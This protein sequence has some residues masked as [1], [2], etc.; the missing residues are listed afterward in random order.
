[1]PQR[2][3]VRDVEEVVLVKIGRSSRD[4]A[5]RLQEVNIGNY[6]PLFEICVI[7]VHDAILVEREL[8]R[9]FAKD[10]LRGEWYALSPTVHQ[11]IG[12][13]IECHE[14]TVLK[15]TA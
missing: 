13:L 10:H 2:E 5:R 9:A 15:R 8:H 14:A 3:V 1:M 4:P 12:F 6:R 11:M 7:P